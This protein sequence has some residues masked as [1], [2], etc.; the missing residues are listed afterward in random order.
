M[1]SIRSHQWSNTQFT[2]SGAY[3][4]SC[5]IIRLLNTIS[6]SKLHKEIGKLFEGIISEFLENSDAYSIEEFDVLL[7]LIEGGECQGLNIGSICINKEKD[8]FT[9][10]GFVQEWYNLKSSNSKED[11]DNELKYFD[12]STTYIQ[13]SYILG[14]IMDKKNYE[15]S[16]LS[17]FDPKEVTIISQLK[18]NQNSFLLNKEIFNKFIKTM[19][20]DISPDKTDSFE[21][22]KRCIGLKILENL[23]KKYPKKLNEILDSELK[24]KLIKI[25]MKESTSEGDSNDNMPFEWVEQKLYVIK[26]LAAEKDVALTKKNEAIIR[27]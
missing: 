4:F 17:L 20:I 5:G 23:I 7:S 13:N 15:K 25:L 16:T 1:F 24:N 21:L 27:F 2:S 3:D 8:T 14:L 22:T 10:I 19:E 18:K 9:V 12:V 6:K 26:R 11:N